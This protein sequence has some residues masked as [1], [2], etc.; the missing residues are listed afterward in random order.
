MHLIETESIADQPL[1]GMGYGS[2]TASEDCTA[3]NACARVCPTAALIL[4]MIEDET[5]YWLKFS[6]LACI[7]CGICAR[8]CEPQALAIDHAPTFD[9]VFGSKEPIVLREG[10]LSR[11][12]RC[13]SLFA[14][15]S[16]V[17][18]CPVCEF[19]RKNP[20]GSKM[21]P[22]IKLRSERSTAEVNNDH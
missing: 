4:G 7:G 19:R 6:P 2:L 17:R 8:V 5:Y 1:S 16:G 22:G 11:C 13:N 10:D 20:F 14:A 9:Q 15:R 12:E 18:L 3:C 21:P